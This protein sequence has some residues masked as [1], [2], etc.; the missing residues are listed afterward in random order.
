MDY[1]EEA[2]LVFRES[3]VSNRSLARQLVSDA[4]MRMGLDNSLWSAEEDKELS[5]LSGNCLQYFTHHLNNACVFQSM[6]LWTSKFKS[7]I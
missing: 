3:V 5:L 6:V 7:G 4:D 1:T 2:T